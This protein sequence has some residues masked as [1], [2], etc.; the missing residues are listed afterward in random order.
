M[1][2]IGLIGGLS[3]LSSLD[4]YRL[5]NELAGRKFGPGNAADVCLVNVNLVE[6]DALLYGGQESKAKQLLLDAALD[7]QHAGA[8]TVALCSNGA[9]TFFD[10]VEAALDVPVMHIADATAREIRAGRIDKVGLLGVRRTMEDDFYRSRLARAGITTI[11]PDDDERTYIHDSIFSE[12]VQGRF[13]EAT[14]RAYVEIING[15]EG[16]GAQGVVLGCT[17][18]PL[19]ID[20]SHVRSRLLP[21]LD[22]HCRELFRWATRPGPAGSATGDP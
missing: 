21:T 17:E 14:R 2:R 5:L 19:L 15:L 8:E 12:L 7:A 16:R 11:V 6:Y 3:W 18:I 10:A 9:H 22:I 20:Q 13:E 1:R 4:Y